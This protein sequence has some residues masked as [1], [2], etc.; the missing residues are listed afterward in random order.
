MTELK[1]SMA[2][3]KERL[4]K[5]VNELEKQLAEGAGVSASSSA[6]ANEVSMP[7]EEGGHDSTHSGSDDEHEDSGGGD[8]HTHDVDGGHAH[9]SAEGSTS[10]N[11]EA[12]S[13]DDD[14]DG[15]SSMLTTGSSGVDVMQSVAW[16]LK[17]QRKMIAAQVQ[18]MAAHS[19]PPLSS[20]EKIHILMKNVGVFG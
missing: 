6:S 2:T 5:H 4:L 20:L 12:D 14:D 17:E 11:H 15:H 9:E 16:L 8:D 13:E 10:D 7:G 1:T 3:E 18:A 19:I